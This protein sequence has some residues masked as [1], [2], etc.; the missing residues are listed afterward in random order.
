MKSEPKIKTI[1]DLVGFIEYEI[2][3]EE[4]ES[5]FLDTWTRGYIAGLGAVLRQIVA[6]EVQNED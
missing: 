3:E 2:E 5:G 4:S 6:T 1:E